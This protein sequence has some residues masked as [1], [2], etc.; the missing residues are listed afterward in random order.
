MIFKPLVLKAG[1]VEQQQA[2]DG[3][4]LNLGPPVISEII[5]GA[6]AVTGSWHAVDS[7]GHVGNDNLDNIL[8]GTA[9][10]ILILTAVSDDRTVTVR[11]NQGNCRLAGNCALNDSTDTLT[12]LYNGIVWLELARA[13]N[14]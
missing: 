5:A 2:G 14:G 12:L 8:G 11:D 9:G 7:E 1:Q 10:D 4:R 13:N 6:I 3:L